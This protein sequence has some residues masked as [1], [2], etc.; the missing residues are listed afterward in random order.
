M[1][2]VS[3]YVAL[4]ACLLSGS[5]ACVLNLLVINIQSSQQAL[6]PWLNGLECEEVF[7]ALR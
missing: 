4:Q 7:K 2:A 5:M 3:S 1:T 6:T